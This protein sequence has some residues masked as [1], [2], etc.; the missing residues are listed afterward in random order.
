MAI[1]SALVLLAVCWF[2]VL[3]VILPI[4][5]TTQGEQGEIVPGTPEGAPYQVNLKRKL[6]LTTIWALVVWAVICAVIISGVI[7]LSEIEFF[8]RLGG[9]APGGN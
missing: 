1:G 7:N 8:N 6:L 3:F 5:L 9:P 4:R 2:M